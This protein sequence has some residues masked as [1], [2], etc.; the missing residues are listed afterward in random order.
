MSDIG[1]TDASRE[2]SLTQAGE[3]WLKLKQAGADASM[4][5]KAIQSPDNE[6]AKELVGTMKGFE[7][8]T[9]AEAQ[10][11]MGQNHFFGPNQWHDFMGWKIKAPPI[12]WRKR[13]LAA[14]AVNHFLFFGVDC[15]QDTLLSIK[16]WIEI[17][18]AKNIPIID[19]EVGGMIHVSRFFEAW[20]CK[21]RWYLMYIGPFPGSQ[22]LY[23]EKQAKLL[24]KIYDPASLVERYIANVLFYQLNKTCMDN[25]TWVIVDPILGGSG[26][27]IIVCYNESK[28]RVGTELG[29]IKAHNIGVSASLIP[30]ISIST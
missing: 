16:K 8:P 23:R 2:L 18:L 4:I 10:A 28:L 29:Y 22:G 3:F 6:I 20:T 25:K 17:L 21:P 14:L 1:N 19:P 5:Q 12:P 7:Y 11:I 24:G 9:L 27:S 30:P 26:D 15:Y 13:E